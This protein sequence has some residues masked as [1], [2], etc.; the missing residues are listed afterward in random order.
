MGEG[1]ADPFVEPF[2]QRLLLR[3]VPGPQMIENEFGDELEAGR[4][5]VPNPFIVHQGRR[6]VLPMQRERAGERGGVL[7]FRHALPECG[8]HRMRRIAQ[9]TVAALH[10]AIKRVPIVEAPFGRANDR[11]G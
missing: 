1:G 9:Q 8:K 11:T 4:A 2:E 3:S 7:E 10:P 6:H 5:V